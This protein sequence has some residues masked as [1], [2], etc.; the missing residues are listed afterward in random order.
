[1]T[2]GGQTYAMP[3]CP[4]GEAMRSESDVN[5]AIERYADMVRR[6]CFVYL[7]NRSDTED[8]FQTV[9][10]K[11]LL[12]GDAFDGAEHEK[13]WFTRVAINACKDLLKSFFRKQV[14]PL[15]LIAER[16]AD[17]ADDDQADVREAVL[18]LP[19]K[20]R[21]V[22]YLFYY[23]GYSAVEIARLLRRRENTV[24]T[25]LSRARKQLKERLGGD[26]LESNQGSV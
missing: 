1:M 23:E 15:D 6:I 9:F 20:Y 17:G 14:V 22:V 21:E 25:L 4:D 13:A 18:S 5:L 8:V 10:L 19:V 2:G 16:A 7:K 12:H 11:Y 26:E 3:A 24:Y